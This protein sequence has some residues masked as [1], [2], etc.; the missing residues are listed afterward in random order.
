MTL[1]PLVFG[2]FDYDCPRGREG[3]KKKKRKEKVLPQV[4]EMIKA[5]SL[6][7]VLSR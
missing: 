3:K 6:V 7:E 2:K 1:S 5:I 4:S